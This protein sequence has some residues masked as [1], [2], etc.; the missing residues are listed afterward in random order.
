M[1]K[2]KSQE[3]AGVRTPRKRRRDVGDSND[4]IEDTV[5]ETSR[6]SVEVDDEITA[7]SD[8]KERISNSPKDLHLKPER[9]KY[10]TRKKR[11]KKQREH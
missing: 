6:D 10:K 8:H 11:K 2:T 4:I 7:P 5:I 9:W 3:P 1:V